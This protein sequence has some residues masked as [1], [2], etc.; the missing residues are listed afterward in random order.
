M[1]SFVSAGQTAFQGSGAILH[2]FQ[3]WMG[4]QC[5]FFFLLCFSLCAV[6]KFIYV[7]C[8]V[9]INTTQD[10]FVWN[11][12]FL[13]QYY[14]YFQIT[15]ETLHSFI[16]YIIPCVPV[17]SLTYHK[18]FKLCSLLVKFLLIDFSLDYRSHYLVKWLLIW[19]VMV[20]DYL[21]VVF[22]YLLLS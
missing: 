15:P 12:T 17:Y 14:F 10:Y 6:F 7:F 3:Q 19:I 16:H 22:C 4:V 21:Y 18:L 8:S 5:S 11:I 13:L 1:F 2:S 9:V 20:M